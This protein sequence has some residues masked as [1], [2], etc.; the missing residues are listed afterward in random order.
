MSLRLTGHLLL[1][2]VRIYAKKADYTLHDLERAKRIIFGHF[3][4]TEHRRHPQRARRAT[5]AAGAHNVSTIQ[6][7]DEGQGMSNFNTY[8]IQYIQHKMF[9]PTNRIGTS[10]YE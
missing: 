5:G 8:L 6:E 9:R 7:E 10:A 2:I 1:G 4:E 3:V